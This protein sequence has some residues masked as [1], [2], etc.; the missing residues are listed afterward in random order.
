MDVSCCA[1]PNHNILVSEHHLEEIWAATRSFEVV[2]RGESES[3][4]TNQRRPVD[5]SVD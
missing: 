3:L 5:N 4:E 1:S 2:S